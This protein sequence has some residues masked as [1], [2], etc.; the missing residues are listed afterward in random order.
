MS[1]PLLEIPITAE[2]IF[3]SR[4]NRFLAHV[5][6]T[7]S[8][9]TVLKNQLVHVHDPGRLEELLFA[10]NK[11]LVKKA[12]NPNR[13]TQWDMIA[14]YFEGMPI[15]INSIFHR[16]LSEKILSMPDLSPI[17][18]INSIKAE[19]KVDNHRLDYFIVDN[20]KNNWWVEV[21]GCTLTENGYALFPDAPTIRGQKHVKKLIEL[22]E[23]GDSTALFILIF[24]PDSTCFAPK[25]NTDP[26]FAKIFYKAVEAGI[27]VFPY[28]FSLKKN[29]ICFERVIPL[30]KKE[31]V[32]KL[33]VK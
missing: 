16:A 32:E 26:A 5:D 29:T 30:C 21:K 18:N 1:T 27:K 31:N 17:K 3:R 2:G 33:W 8:N 11:V 12:D 14:A 23:K 25:H 22:Q 4:P 28:V 10:G 13:K 15:L 24:R 9:S 20:K 6:I 7:L 19:A